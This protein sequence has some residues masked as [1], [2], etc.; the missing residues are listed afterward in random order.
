MRESFL[1][2][3][4]REKPKK[5]DKRIKAKLILL[6]NNAVSFYCLWWLYGEL[7]PKSKSDSEYLREAV[8][9]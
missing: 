4:R 5:P 9:V 7:R 8:A 3:R 1:N 2:G 6:K